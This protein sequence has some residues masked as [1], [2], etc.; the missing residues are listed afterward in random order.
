MAA[1]TEKTF[2]VEEFVNL[3]LDTKV[4]G[5]KIWVQG[6]INGMT[7]TS[8]KALW[9][10]FLKQDITPYSARIF[11]DNILSYCDQTKNLTRDVLKRREGFCLEF[12]QKAAE[13]SVSPCLPT[14]QA[15][16]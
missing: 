1:E 7:T 8:K 11:L 15:L 5:A 6:Y 3:I 14:D 9:E 10:R 13:C 12:L 4:E 2:T 16:T